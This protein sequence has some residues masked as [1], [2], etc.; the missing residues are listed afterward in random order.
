MGY[1]GPFLFNG[2]RFALG[3][4]ALLPFVVAARRRDSDGDED[5]PGRPPRWHY[6]LLGAVLFGGASLQQVG[7]VYTTAGRA[8]FITGLYVV[9]VPIL[10][11]RVRRRPGPE[12]WA[13]AGLAVAGLYLLSVRRG[14][15]IQPGDLLVLAC[16]FFWAA[17]IL[18]VDRMAQ[19]RHWAALAASQFGICAA[20]SLSIALCFEEFSTTS[21]GAAWVPLVY[22]G[23]LSVGVG[24][25][26]QIVAQR[27]APP[28]PAAIIM[29]LETVF[30]AL[31]GWLLLGEVLDGRE[32]CGCGLMLGGMVV[33]QVRPRRRP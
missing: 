30:A 23:I 29:S 4:L 1:I 8:G 20:A 11:L 15:S 9:I 31:G 3:C 10:G 7:I 18:L 27:R 16:A 33:S 26:L 2:I 21:I 17:H 13:G 22:A 19:Q 24:Y 5:C 28:A 6:L 14:F 32:L 12:T 25:S